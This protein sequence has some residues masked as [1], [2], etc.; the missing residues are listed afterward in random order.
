MT[1]IAIL[2]D[3]QHVALQ[4]A[5][6]DRLR[7]RGIA[8][9][10]MSEPFASE[11][12]AAAALADVEIIVP[13]RERTPFPASLIAR[14]PQL[15]LVALTGGRAPTLDIAACTQRGVLVC[16]TG[17]GEFSTAATAELAWALLLAAYRNVPQADALIRSGRWHEALPMGESLD[18]KRLGIVGLGKLGARVA[19]FGQAF[20]ME[21]VAWSQNLTDEAA[22]AHGARRVSKDELFATADAVTLHLVLSAR[23]RGIV[24]ASELAAMKQG[25][26]LINTSRGPLVDEAALLATLKSGRITA[27]LDVFGQEPLPADH[28]LRSAP[29]TVLTPHLG[30][31]SWPVMHRFYQDSVENIE[32]WL[33]GAPIR[34]LNP[35]ALGR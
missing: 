20:G 25:A 15:R 23:S 18:G 28:P 34:M 26:V 33:D 29:N 17:G 22:I 21:V 11:D 10:V 2:D 4:A 9:A 8:I 13:M 12:A 31:S 16:N 35:E 19:R 3:S 32:A 14:L 24:G 30:Y 6:W 7:K 5:D 1:K 27:A